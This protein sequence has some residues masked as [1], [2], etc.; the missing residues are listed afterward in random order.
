MIQKT[1]F[2]TLLIWIGLANGEDLFGGDLG[3]PDY[4][5]CAIHNVEYE[6]WYLLSERVMN[7]RYRTIALNRFQVFSDSNQGVWQ[8]VPTNHTKNSFYLRNKKYSEDLYADT[9]FA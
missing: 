3:S 6:K 7:A 9:N 2:V 8:F 4:A 1:L 5:E